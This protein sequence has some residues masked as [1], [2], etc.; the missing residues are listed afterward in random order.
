MKKIALTIIA[1]ACTLSLGAQDSHMLSAAGITPQ[2]LYINPAMMPEHSYMS[3]PLI[4]SIGLNVGTSL[5]YGSLVKNGYIDGASLARD[6]KDKAFRTDISLDIFSFGIRFREDNLISVSN[7]LRVGLGT[8]YPSGLLGYIFDNPIDYSGSFDI[9]LKADMLAWNEM[10]IGYSRRINDNWSVGGRVKYVM[11]LARVDTRSTGFRIEKNIMGSTVTG[12][13]DI[14]GGNINFGGDK[15]F[16]PANLTSSPGA[17]FDIGAAWSS[18]DARWRIGAAISDIG[19]IRWSGKS[20]SRIYSSETAEYRF[21]GFGDLDEIFGSSSFD[22]MLDSV[23]NELL[24]CMELDTLSGYAHTGMMPLTVNVSG[25]FDVRGD[26]RHVVSLDLLGTFNMHQPLYYAV[27]A[28]YRYTT[29]NGR[30]SAIA[31]LSHK[32]VDPVS[33]GVGLMAN[34]RNFQFFMLGDTSVYALA[35]NLRKTSGMSLR[36]GFN[37]F[38]GN[39]DGYCP[40]GGEKYRYVNYF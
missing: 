30:F 18:D 3:I 24:D 6:M 25:E 1:L 26:K 23:Y 10:A 29:D 13:V 14:T 8:G 4:G 28:G 37:F 5:G 12:D 40:R 16:D 7:R 39:D 38:F 22:D 21:D 9:P 20:S 35:G 34:T 2:R 36:M 17:A 32:R 15:L 11:G 33:I 31:T 27:T 19:F